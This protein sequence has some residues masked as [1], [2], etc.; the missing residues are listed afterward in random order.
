MSCS[1]TASAAAV[2]GARVASVARVRPDLGVQAGKGEALWK[3]LFVTDADLLVFIDADLTEWGPHFV[4]GLIGPLLADPAVMLVRGFYDRVLDDGDV[5]SLEGGRVTELV[6]RP[7]LALHRPALSGVIQPL[8]GEWAVRRSAFEALPVP[9]G[10]GVELSTLLDVHDRHGLEAI[11]Q[12]DLGRRAHRHQSLHDL[13]AMALELMVIADRRGSSRP[14]PPATDA[15][16]LRAPLPDRSWSE[17][18]V[19]VAERPPWRDVR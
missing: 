16:R 10:Y 7:W 5:P 13:G 19:P 2:A 17:R 8:A 3:S 11:V 12:V 4:T 6:A 14:A 9:V 1:V 15:V 18:T